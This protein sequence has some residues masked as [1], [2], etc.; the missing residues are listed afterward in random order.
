MID[1]YLKAPTEAEMNAALV[2]AG[3][4]IDFDGE[5]QPPVGVSI[6]NIGPF[7]RWDYSVEP[8]VEIDY[9]DWHTNVRAY[10]IAKDQMAVLAPFIIAPPPALPYRVWA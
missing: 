8:P 10:E 2:S 5:L 3:L 9:P 1:L 6:D 7:V 4:L